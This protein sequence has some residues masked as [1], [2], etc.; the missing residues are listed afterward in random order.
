MVSSLKYSLLWSVC[1][2]FSLICYWV[3]CYW[4]I[5]Y[6]ISS[7]TTMQR[8]VS[9]NSNSTYFLLKTLILFAWTLK[10]KQ[11]K[12]QSLQFLNVNEI[13]RKSCSDYLPT[14]FLSEAILMVLFA[15]LP[16]FPCVVTPVVCRGL[17]Y[18]SSCNNDVFPNSPKWLLMPELR[19]LCFV[20]R[21]GCW[22]NPWAGNESVVLCPRE[23]LWLLSFTSMWFKTK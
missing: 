17:F 20:R 12:N 5:C 21:G 7:Q 6:Y 2:H 22:W 8:P 11:T 18:C 15:F 1:T 14:S 9:F 19:K 16:C 4:V 3:I 13:R 10:W 23:L